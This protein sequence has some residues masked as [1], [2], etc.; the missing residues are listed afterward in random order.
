MA[1]HDGHVG[2]AKRA[3]R[4]DVF[5]VAAAQEFSAHQPDEA[6][7]GEQRHHAEQD[8]EARRQH[9]RYDQEQIEIGNR[10]PDFDEPLEA[11]IDPA[12]EITLH[13]AGDDA[14]DRGD[15]CQAQSEQH[16]DSE[17]V[18]QP[19]DYVAALIVGTEPVVFEVTAAREAFLLHHATALVLGQEPGRL[20]R[21]RRRQV[22]IVR[23]VGIAD[24][25]P[26]D[27]ATLFLDQLLQIGIA[28]VGRGLE[29]AAEGRLRIGDE[30]RPVQMAVIL[31]HERLVVGDHT[32]RTA[33][34]RTGP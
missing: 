29:I 4:L 7:P 3:R 34:P 14:D 26:D 15:Q 10:I 13:A 33:R 18:D 31:D 22:E 21:R 27:G 17:A 5:E 25:R 8:E 16:R 32:R 6:D 1:E 23:I 9:R 12:A 2:D 20:R 28:I 11:E 30:G 24:Q 19:R